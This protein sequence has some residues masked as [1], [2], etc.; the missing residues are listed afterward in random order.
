MEG[1]AW[2]GL[3]IG[4]GLFLQI[5]W[6]HDRYAAVSSVGIWREPPRA[7]M[8]VVRH[9]RGPIIASAAIIEAW[10]LALAVVSGM[11]VL[12]V[13][14]GEVANE[15]TRWV[16]LYLGIAVVAAFLVIAVLGRRGTRSE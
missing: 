10:C 13:I 2:L 1:I 7:L 3:I 8:M 4:V 14:A 9:T 12:G 6:S 11:T 5:W 15:A 16:V